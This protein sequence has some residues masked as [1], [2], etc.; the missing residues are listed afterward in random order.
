MDFQTSNSGL[1]DDDRVGWM[2]TNDSTSSNNIFG[3]Q[4]D[5]GGSGQNIEC[6]WDGDSF[7][8]DGGRTSIVDLPALTANAWYRLQAGIT[9]LTATSARIDV[10]LWELDAGGDLGPVVVTGS[11][12]DTDLLPNTSG[13][14]IPNPGYFTGPI[15]PAF[16][17]YSAMEGAADNACYEVIT[18]T[19]AMNKAKAGSAEW[20]MEEVAREIPNANYLAANQPNPFNPNTTIRFGLLEAGSVELIIFDIL[21]QKV[22]TLI[23]D[24]YPAGDHLVIWDG[25][26]DLGHPV[27]SGVYFYRLVNPGFKQVRKMMLIK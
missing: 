11:I 18:T 12:P 20:D 19:L 6:Y 2:I 8:D 21:G 24:H 23:R 14:E 7:G 25:R 5:P 1:F 10:T 9:R 17:N 22:R 27:A 13:N 15:W 26:N 4:L 16:K 3:V